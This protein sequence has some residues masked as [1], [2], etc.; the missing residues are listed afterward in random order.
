MDRTEPAH[1]ALAL[2]C[3]ATILANGV[4]LLGN[5]STAIPQLPGVILADVLFAPLRIAVWVLFWAYWFRIVHIRWVHGMVWGLAALLMLGTAMLRPPLYGQVVPVGAAGVLFPALLTVKLLMAALLIVI[6][7]YGI[8]KSR[9]EGWTAMAA[10]LLVGI[11][12]YQRELRL[13]HIRIRYSLFDFNLS[14]GTIATI[15]SLCLITVML[16]RR[17]LQ[18]QRRREQWKAEIEQARQVQHV[19]IP[20]ELPT[21][22]GFVIE[23]EYRPAREVGGD[24]FQILPLKE[25]GS[26]LIVVGDVTGKGLQAGMLVA[27]IVGAIRTAVEY[28]TDPVHLLNTLNERLCGR[29]RA[30]ATCMILRI[31]PDGAV[32]LANAG[33]L[34]PYWNGEELEMEGA[35]PIGVASDPDFPVMHFQ[36]APGDRL[37]LMS[38]G[39]AEAQDRHGKLFGFDRIQEMV[40]GRTSAV[41]LADAAQAFG[42]EDDILVLEIRRNGGGRDRLET[43][44]VLTAT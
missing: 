17:F 43:S 24:F 12:L 31:A 16:L 3:V 21:V 28:H 42:Q 36:L 18:G 6:T 7:V 13:L 27:L 38:D 23:S 15:V 22:P 40:R 4:V 39:L 30:S 26:V 41:K 34:P 14:L 44:A 1:L 11:S 10:V 37:M 9:A 20:H 8:R 33:H 35:L 25:D 32:T 19:L 2:V 29:G 5:F